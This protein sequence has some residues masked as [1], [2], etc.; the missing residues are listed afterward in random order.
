MKIAKSYASQNSHKVGIANEHTEVR[1]NDHEDNLKKLET[2]F[3]KPNSKRGKLDSNLNELAHQF[4]DVNMPEKRLISEEQPQILDRETVG[5]YQREDRTPHS[6]KLHPDKPLSSNQKL[7]NKECALGESQNL[8]HSAHQT[9]LRVL[10]EQNEALR[11]ANR[12]LIEDSRELSRAFD[13]GI[14]QLKS[15]INATNYHLE[16]ENF[17]LKKEVIDFKVKYS[18]AI[19][20]ESQLKLKLE[21]KNSECDSWHRQFIAAKKELEKVK[22]SLTRLAERRNKDGEG[23]KCVDVYSHG[24]DPVTEKGL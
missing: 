21:E 23:R 8:L 12:R 14:E 10:Q 4:S 15:D 18:N 7:P 13:K 1:K 16:S 19:D 6:S 2:A 17:D 9:E 20:I 22:S 5:M 3:K 24:G 11:K